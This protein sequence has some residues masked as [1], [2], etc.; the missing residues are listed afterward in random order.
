MWLMIT[1]SSVYQLCLTSK[2][3][4]HKCF[5]V[6]SFSKSFDSSMNGPLIE[7]LTFYLC[8]NVAE[9]YSTLVDLVNHCV[10]FRFGRNGF[11][12]YLWA[13]SLGSPGWDSKKYHQ[14]GCRAA[15]IE[16]PIICWSLLFRLLNFSQVE[17]LFV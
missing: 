9:R 3:K 10:F 7:H 12:N 16:Q 13:M 15:G 6:C 4:I 8:I 2:L 1:I 11:I 17:Y 14:S 5:G